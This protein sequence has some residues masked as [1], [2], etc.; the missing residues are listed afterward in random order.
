MDQTI[1]VLSP[2]RRL[3]RRQLLPSCILS[4]PNSFFSSH[5]VFRLLSPLS[6]LLLSPTLVFLPVKGPAALLPSLA[7][8][9]SN[10]LPLW[11]LAPAL[12]PLARR[13]AT[14]PP[15]RQ[16]HL[17]PLCLKLLLVEDLR[18]N[19]LLNARAGPTNTTPRTLR[20]RL[21]ARVLNLRQPTLRLRHLSPLWTPHHR[22]QAEKSLLLFL[23]RL[24]LL[25]L[26]P[27]PSG[28]R[29]CR[30]HQLAPR[31]SLPLLRGMA[32]LTLWL[33]YRLLPQPLA[34]ALRPAS[35]W[36]LAR[37]P[38]SALHPRAS[39]HSSVM[40]RLSQGSSLLRPL[41]LPQPKTLLWLR[42]PTRLLFNR[43]WGHCLLVLRHRLPWPSRR[44]ILLS[45]IL[46]RLYHQ[47]H[48]TV[49]LSQTILSTLG[50]SAR[51]TNCLALLW[52][53]H[54]PTFTL[55]RPMAASTC[56]AFTC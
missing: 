23:P 7:P 13:P 48:E 6:L 18:A 3:L 35:M 21:L 2:C 26:P 28:H 14:A 38:P 30:P 32:K 24:R 51:P 45:L 43:P 22:P 12:L 34:L 19:G 55:R 17:L 40:H 15:R 56:S 52:Q 25:S 41:V 16:T 33:L 1:H 5:K 54:F 36:L 27:R 42:P 47:F 37:K 11:P 39:R 4:R 46:L 50:Y 20:T 10:R 53:M 49:R 44:L 29:V 31:A 8:A 9:R